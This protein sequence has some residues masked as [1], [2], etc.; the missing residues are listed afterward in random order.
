MFYCAKG[1]VQS[2][3]VLKVHTLPRIYVLVLPK[4]YMATV[5]TVGHQCR[6]AIVKND[7]QG[8]FCIC[9]LQQGTSVQDCHCQE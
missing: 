2:Q 6:I 7:F 9:L 5:N 8:E 4:D 1:L 3:K